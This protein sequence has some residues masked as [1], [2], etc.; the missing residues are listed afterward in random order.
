MLRHILL[1]R[2]LV[3]LL[4]VDDK[5][6]GFLAILV[7]LTSVGAGNLEKLLNRGG[8][9]DNWLGTSILRLATML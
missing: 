1:R 4:V 7:S 5:L 6:L 2:I 9:F 3:V 8:D